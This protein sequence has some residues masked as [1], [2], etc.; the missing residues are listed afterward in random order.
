MPILPQII[1]TIMIRILIIM[2]TI[3]M[4]MIIIMVYLT[5]PPCGSSLLNYR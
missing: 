4:V 5:F 3:F 2:I 1:I